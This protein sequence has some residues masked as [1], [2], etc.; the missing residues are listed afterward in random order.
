VT[1]QGGVP[2]PG[3]VVFADLDDDGLL[4]A[5]EPSSLS[6]A[7]TP[8]FPLAGGGYY[9]QGIPAGEVAIRLVNPD[10]RAF[11]IVS[12]ADGFHTVVV[13]DGEV[14]AGLDFELELRVG[15]PDEEPEA[16]PGCAA[17]GGRALP[18]WLLL[19]SMIALRRRSVC[20]AR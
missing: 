10:A 15:D 5:G 18:L 9:L 1:F 20:G 11:A 16:E 6:F 3:L 8:A 19:L 17:T 14:V 7:S 2:F 12:P 4:G 13:S